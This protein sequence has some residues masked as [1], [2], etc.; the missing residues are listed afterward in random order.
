MLYRDSNTSLQTEAMLTSNRHKCKTSYI[1]KCCTK[2][3][4]NLQYNE[5]MGYLTLTL[6]F[7]LLNLHTDGV[8]SRK[9]IDE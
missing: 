3:S 8:I 7:M 9:A 1:D 6:V 5:R 2:L 4:S